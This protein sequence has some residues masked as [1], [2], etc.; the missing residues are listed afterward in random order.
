MRKL[1]V[2]RRTR[3]PKKIGVNGEF[4]EWLTDPNSQTAGG[5]IIDFG[6]YGG[7]SRNIGLMQAKKNQLQS[8]AV[9]QQFST[10]KQSES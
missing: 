8:T 1:I 10:R 3:G 5:A 2:P 4:L 7:Q 6:C 9:A